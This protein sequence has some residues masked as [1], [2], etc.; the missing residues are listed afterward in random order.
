[1]TEKLK[2]TRFEKDALKNRKKEEQEEELMMIMMNC[3][4][5]RYFGWSVLT[6]LICDNATDIT[7]YNRENP[8]MTS[9]TASAEVI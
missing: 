1:M 2:I 4:C 6:Y 7:N 3:G 9:I 5:N 8:L